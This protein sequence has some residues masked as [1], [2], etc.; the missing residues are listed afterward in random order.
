MVKRITTIGCVLAAAL[1][2]PVIASAALSP[3]DYK[4]S[5]KFC[6]ALRADMGASLFKTTYGTNH[7]H[8][9]AHGKC[10]SKYVKLEDQVHAFARSECKTEQAADPTGFAERFGS[11]QGGSNNNHPNSN[12]SDKNALG[13]CTSQKARA[14]EVKKQDQIVSAA[15]DCR[16]ERSDLGADAFRAKYGKNHNDRNAFGK[17]V[18]QKVKN[19]TTS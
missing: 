1:V 7:N 13:K 16:G 11:D 5:S 18:S 2:V 10:V 8:S 9:N 3:T 14:Q 15:R 17:C 6:K 4:N 19:G 12:G